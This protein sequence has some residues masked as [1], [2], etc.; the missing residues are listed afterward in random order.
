MCAQVVRFVS[1]RVPEGRE[2][3]VE[4]GRRT[5]KE[6]GRRRR[7]TQERERQKKEEADRTRT[8]QTREGESGKGRKGR[9]TMRDLWRQSRQ[10]SRRRPRFGRAPRAMSPPAHTCTQLQPGSLRYRLLTLCPAPTDPVGQSWPRGTLSVGDSVSE[11]TL[12]ERVRERGGAEGR[13][14]GGGLR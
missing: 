12:T 9:E 4:E 2:M 6:Q 10:D 13:R 3:D 7:K 11:G 1:E 8:C 5:H 14:R